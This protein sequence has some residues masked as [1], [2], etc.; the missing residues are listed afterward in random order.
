VPR[1]ADL[2]QVDSL[3]VRPVSGVV[4]KQVTARDVVSKGQRQLF[5]TLR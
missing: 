2:V 3:D 1:P 4:F 5:D